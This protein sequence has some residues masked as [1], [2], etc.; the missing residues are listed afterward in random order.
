M[1]KLSI[2]LLALFF[3]LVLHAQD[4]TLPNLVLKDVNGKSVDVASYGKTGK[5]TIICLWATWCKPCI[6]EI[7]N[8]TELMEEWKS[9][10]G[11]QLVTVSVDNARNVP[12]VKPFVDGQGWDYD[13]LL[14]V[15]EDL[16]RALNAPSVPY[17][18]VLDKNG[19]IVYEHNGY[20]PGDE[21]AL[22]EKLKHF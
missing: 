10:Y 18:I 2:T 6:Q 16:K 20:L 9:K 4:K 13:V 8:I 19:K 17:M 1:K 3:V 14:D 21:F 12:K 22:E 15:N 5:I 7:N 11:V